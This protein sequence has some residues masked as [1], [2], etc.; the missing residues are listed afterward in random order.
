[1]CG[2]PGS[3]GYT[4]QEAAV[5]QEGGEASPRSGGWGGTW[6]REFIVVSVESNRGCR[7]SRLRVFCFE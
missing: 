3:A 2:M 6:A 1:M 7:R 5:G 4:R